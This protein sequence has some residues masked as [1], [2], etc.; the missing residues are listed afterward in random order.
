MNPKTLWP[1]FMMG[2][3]CVF[4]YLSTF[5]GAVFMLWLDPTGL[6]WAGYLFGMMAG[7]AGMAYVATSPDLD[8]NH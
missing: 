2:R 5:G 6:A 1:R 7:V 4:L 8:P 3:L